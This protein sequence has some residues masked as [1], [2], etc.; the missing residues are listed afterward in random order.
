MKVNGNYY[1]RTEETSYT[2]S[3]DKIGEVKYKTPKTDGKYE[4]QDF[5]AS[6]LYLSD[7]KN[8]IY[9]KKTHSEIEVFIKYVWISPDD[10]LLK[11]D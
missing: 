2:F 10:I 4:Y 11:K 9:V 3:G 5:E 6:E 7:E 1:E 8:E